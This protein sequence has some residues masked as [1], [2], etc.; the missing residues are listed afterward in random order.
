MHATA[1]PEI[2]QYV[3]ESNA[4]PDYPSSVNSGILGDPE[5]YTANSYH[6]PIHHLPTPGG[7]TNSHQDDRVPA[8]ENQHVSADD[9]S[10]SLADMVKQWNRYLAV[11][12]NPNDPRRKY[13]AE[14]IGYNG[15]GE[16]ERLDFQKNTRTNAS[17]DHKWHAHRANRRKY[18]NSRTAYQARLSIDRGQT[19]AQYEGNEN[20]M[21]GQ[22]DWRIEAEIYDRDKTAST[23]DFPNGEVNEPKK[24]QMAAHTAVMAKL[25]EIQVALA[26]VGGPTDAQVTAQT[27]AIVAALEASPAVTFGPEDKAVVTEAVQDALRAGTG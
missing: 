4:L 17:R 7:Y 18:H 24:R 5:H 3:N 26:S 10:M 1:S 2:I 23:P 27:E 21:P 12:N 16:A 13:I 14:Y 11:F 8:A 15:V 22:T 25:T 19:V 20:T 9:M 6:I